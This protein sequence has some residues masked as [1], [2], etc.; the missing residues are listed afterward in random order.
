MDHE[1]DMWVLVG[2]W[3]STSKVW[4]PFPTADDA[5]EWCNVLGMTP[6]NWEVLPL[7]HPGQ[8]RPTHP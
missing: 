5:R 1:N 2:T 6:A 8:R 3:G 7:Q 4:P